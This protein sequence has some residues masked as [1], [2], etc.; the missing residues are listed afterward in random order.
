MNEIKEAINYANKGDFKSAIRILES[1]NKIHPED[2]DILYNLGMCYTEM[3]DPQKTIDLLE[4][5]KIKTPYFPNIHVA[6]GYSYFKINDFDNAESCFRIA[7]KLDPNNEFALRNLGG[8]YGKLNRYSDSIDILKKALIQN[9][10]D[11]QSEY[12]L[13]IAYFYSQDIEKADEHLKN[14]IKGSNNSDLLQL[15]KDQRSEIAEINLKSSGFRVDVMF[16]CLGA[17]E[18]YK[19]CNKIDIQNISFEIGLKGQDG[20]DVLNPDIKYSLKSMKGEFTGL[21]LVSYM[22]VGF[23]I[24]APEVDVGMDFSEEHK[25]ANELFNK[26]RLDAN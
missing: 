23:K 1:L 24:F 13:A 8:I 4:N 11:M 26:N 5:K 19:N 2:T 18:H 22:Y 21:Q 7:L 9:P 14:V 20:L 25:T 10:D 12:G 15:A 3:G 17:L 6:L 16:Y